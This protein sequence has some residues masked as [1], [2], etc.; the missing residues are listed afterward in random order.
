MGKKN[1]WF[2][3]VKKLFISESQQKPEKKQK[4]WK[5]VF[6][7]MRN[8]RL[9]TLTAPLPPK[10]TTTSRQEEEEEEEERKQ[11]LSVAIAST[12]AAEAAVAAAKA[13]VEVVWLTGTTQSHQQEAAEE[14]F[15]PLKKAPPPDLLKHEREIHEFAA[16]TIQTA[17]RGF[18]ARK[19]LR[20]LKGIVRLQAIIRGRAVRRQAIATLK[21]LQSIVSIQSQVCSNRLHLPQN[22]YN[23]PETRQFQSL[24]D[25]IIKLDSND[26]RWDD[27]LLSKE[28]ADAVFLS[29]KE[30]V[31]RRERVK[32]YLFAHRRSAESERKKV[33]GRWRYWLDQW[34]DTQLSKSKELEDLDS[35]FTSNPK[36]KETT[37]ERFKPNPTTKNMDR[38]TEEHPPNQSPS[39]KPALKSPFHHKKQRSLGGAIDSNSSFSSSPLVPTYM[40]ATESA[41]AKSRSLSSPKLRPAGGLDT[42]SDGNSP[43]KTKQL[44]LVSSM[45]SEVGISSGRR[46]FHQQQRSP[47]LKGLPGPTRSSRT[48][49]KDLSI[50]SEHS[51]P[52][53]DRQSAFP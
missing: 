41:K 31:I 48:L 4:R 17:F 6:G 18:L 49:T 45:V 34:V 36:H 16:I 43:C 44:C 46:G 25:K 50:D 29:R 27:S 26:Q 5:W 11:A 9:A 14:V 53:W 3:L 52:N 28:E 32:E 30:A 23:S 38:T 7:K 20:A 1:G 42:C 22:T 10:A 21:C 47:G 24:K 13:A 39:R 37:N 19:A 33:R 40:A 51:L 15:K 2:Y 12:A 8:K 35:I